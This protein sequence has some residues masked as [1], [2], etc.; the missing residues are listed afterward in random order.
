MNEN[1]SNIGHVEVTPEGRIL[2]AGHCDFASANVIEPIAGGQ[3]VFMP[4]E[5]FE[6]LGLLSNWYYDAGADEFIERPAIPPAPGEF[7]A[8]GGDS[9]AFAFPAGTEVRVNDLDPIV[10]EGNDGLTITTDEP[11]EILVVAQPPFPYLPF[12]QMV[13]ANAP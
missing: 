6:N 10:I 8:D 12:R 11:G 2:A 4:A 7:L 5:R 9:I 3:L 13:T 1:I